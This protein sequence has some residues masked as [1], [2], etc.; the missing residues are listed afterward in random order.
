VVAQLECLDAAQA[1]FEA[2]GG[3]EVEAR[4]SKVLQGLGFDPSEF[5]SRCSSFSGGWQMR[6]GL[7]RLLLS[8]PELL[9]MDEPTNHLD[10]AARRW[11]GDYVGAYSGTVLVVSHDAEFVGRASNSIAEVAGGRLE[12]YKSTT[13]D[14]YV[15]PPAR[16][17]ASMGPHLLTL[18]APPR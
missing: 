7:A 8:E 14:K 2:A 17:E 6:I 1:A 13:H 9:I 16:M 4:V 12:L 18:R 11:L 5:D 15:A 10:A 3:Y